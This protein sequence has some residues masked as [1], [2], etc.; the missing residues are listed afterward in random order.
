MHD[1]DNEMLIKSYILCLFSY[2][3]ALFT[4]FIVL[5]MLVLY[6]PLL[7]LLI[8]DLSATLVIFLIGTLYKNA[9]FYDPYWSVF[10]IFIALF[11][12][13]RSGGLALSF[14][15]QLV[16]LLLVFTWSVRLTYNWIRQWK[17]IKH[18][19]WRYSNLRFKKGK[20]FW[21]VNLTGI[22]F[23][24]T[25]LVFLGSL[26]LYPSLGT[27]A[28]PFNFIDIIATLIT[29]SAIAIETIADQQLNKFIKTRQ[30]IEQIIQRGLWKYS[31]HPNYFG[32]IL[33]WCGLYLFALA[34]DISYW[35]M[36][37]G[38]ICVIILFLGVSIPLMER[39]M[40]KRPGYALYK[41]KVSKLIPWPSRD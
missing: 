20:T 28:T 25:I 29:F 18:E 19:D 5:L 14:T 35:W 41:S 13:I 21:L 34:S 38:P 10:P 39:R 24:P 4:A 31:R 17:G 7:A 40:L 16:V 1:R 33:F 32:E 3:I 2:L 22:H 36:I 27:T 11:W 15:R 37:I 6:P 26:S 30:D 9:S 8:A 23:M 12:I